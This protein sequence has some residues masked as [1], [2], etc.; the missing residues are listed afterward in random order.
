MKKKLKIKNKL[1]NHL[2]VNGNKKTSEKVLLKSF[3]KL[4]KESIKQSKKIFQLAI[5]NSTTVFKI[6][7]YITKKRKKANL[8]EIPT[9]IKNTDNR[10]SLAIKNILKNKINK[11]NTGKFFNEL[12]KEIL[13]TSQNKGTT[14]ESK[15]TLQ[16]QIPLK[17]RLFAFYK[18]K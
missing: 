1:I 14:I 2:T 3:K 6:N 17:K 12:K 16:K 5:I 7:K 15:N 18:W 4:Q 13:L 8:K 10:T 9:F 11:K